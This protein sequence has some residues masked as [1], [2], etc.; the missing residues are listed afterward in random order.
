MRFD[1]ESK[2]G[3]MKRPDLGRA[4]N[5]V[6]MGATEVGEEK[7]A[8]LIEADYEAE[9]PYQMLLLE[10]PYRVLRR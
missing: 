7:R 6:T 10:P 9:T 8:R 1:V 5:G 4:G 3:E 2:Y